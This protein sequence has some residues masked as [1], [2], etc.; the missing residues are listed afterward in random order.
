MPSG[1]GYELCKS[2]CQQEGHAEENALSFAGDKAKGATLY[3]EG[4]TYACGNCTSIA[5]QYGVKE[6]IIVKQNS[7]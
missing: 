7:H 1:V 2:V 4:H 3:V 6:I 5:E